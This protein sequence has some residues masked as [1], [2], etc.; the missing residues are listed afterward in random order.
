MAMVLI[1]SADSA[2]DRRKTRRAWHES[3]GMKAEGGRFRRRRGVMSPTRAQRVLRVP[4]K[5]SSGPPIVCATLQTRQS[6]GITSIEK[7]NFSDSI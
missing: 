1:A 4:C 2:R 6:W 5:Q 3:H 7:R